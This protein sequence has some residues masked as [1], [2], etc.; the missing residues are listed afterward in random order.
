MVVPGPGVLIVGEFLVG[1]P[2]FFQFTPTSL[3]FGDLLFDEGGEGP[4]EF[5]GGDALGGE[6]VELTVLTGVL[7]T[8]AV[9][10]DGVPLASEMNDLQGLG[11]RVEVGGHGEIT[12]LSE[13]E[14][15]GRA[16]VCRPDR[17]SSVA[18][19]L[20]D[21]LDDPEDLLLTDLTLVERV[22]LR[23]PLLE[24]VDVVLHRFNSDSDLY[25][26]FFCLFSF[27]S[28]IYGRNVNYLIYNQNVSFVP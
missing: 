4:E 3:L 2:L 1:F 27:W 21:L 15:E 28:R 7:D 14:S 5:L 12:H 18:D 6:L 25:I 20:S 26:V 22:V 8:G 19:V 9:D 17:Q 11:P 16:N 24:G 10:H 13:E 23:G